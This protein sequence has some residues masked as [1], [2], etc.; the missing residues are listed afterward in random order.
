M[1]FKNIM[2]MRFI[3]LGVVLREKSALAYVMVRTSLHPQ[4]DNTSIMN[5]MYFARE[6]NRPYMG[7]YHF[8]FQNLR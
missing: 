2:M 6:L 3:W 8:Y 7:F 5:N 1:K 4:H